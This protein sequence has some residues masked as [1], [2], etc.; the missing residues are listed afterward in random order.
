MNRRAKHL[1]TQ[2]KLTFKEYA[3]FSN[4]MLCT[5]FTHIDEATGQLLIYKSTVNTPKRC[6]EL[7]EKYT[8]HNI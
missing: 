6:M 4:G 7:E 8:E 3:M 5:I 2:D 1:E